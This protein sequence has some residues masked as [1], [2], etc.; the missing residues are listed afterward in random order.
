MSGCNARPPAGQAEKRGRPSAGSRGASRAS[1]PS[2]TPTPDRPRLDGTPL[3]PLFT[4]NVM[5]G[6]KST[7]ST[8]M[9]SMVV[10][11][12]HLEPTVL[13]VAPSSPRNRNSDPRCN[14]A[15]PSTDEVAE[16]ALPPSGSA[17]PALVAMVRP[18]APPCRSTA[19]FGSVFRIRGATPVWKS[20]S[21]LGYLTRWSRRQRPHRWRKPTPSSRRSY[22]ESHRWRGA[23][24]I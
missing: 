6:T 20:A 3:S 1:E 12:R 15:A 10:I 11:G 13:V 22:E 4:S 14:S 5:T 21:E 2:A 7:P 17:G 9:R 24:E 23:P 16:V 19:S 18:P 8:A